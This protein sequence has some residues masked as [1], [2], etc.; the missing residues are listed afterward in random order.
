MKSNA[1][2]AK[3]QKREAK[4]AAREAKEKK[5]N[6]ALH[7]KLVQPIKVEKPEVDQSI[8]DQANQVYV[9]RVEKAFNDYLNHNIA[10][11]DLK[12]KVKQYKQEFELVTHGKYYHQ[13][14]KLH[15]KAGIDYPTR[16][17]RFNIYQHQKEYQDTVADINHDIQL[18]KK[19]PDYQNNKLNEQYQA[20][21]QTL[22]TAKES[23]HNKY[24][25]DCQKSFQEF[26]QKIYLID[27]IKDNNR[28]FYLFKAK[29]FS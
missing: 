11:S 12:L 10:D 28:K 3:T 25:D 6:Q 27:E 22:K 7:D 18:I 21:L 23:A 2:V 8:I 14:C 24:R 17:Y 9:Q 4:L 13:L 26:S 19:D 16:K 1:N 29:A 5:Q 15:L 20:R